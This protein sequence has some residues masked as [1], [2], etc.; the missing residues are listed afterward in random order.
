MNPPSPMI[1]VMLGSKPSQRCPTSTGPSSVSSRPFRDLPEEKP[2][3]ALSLSE[4]ASQIRRIRSAKHRTRCSYR[5][6]RSSLKLR[7]STC[8]T[9][10]FQNVHAG[11]GAVDDVNVAAIVDLNVVRLDRDLAALLRA[12]TDAALVGFVGNS[13]N[14]IADFLRLQWITHVQ[15]AHAGIEVGDKENAP[16]VNGR[17]VFIRRVG[18]ETAAALAEIAAR[19]WNCPR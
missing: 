14:V 5:S 2:G 3:P 11:I 13:G 15:S 1:Q 4:H 19:F 17:H 8:R 18:S 16:V 6:G 9:A 12:R 7:D 10:E